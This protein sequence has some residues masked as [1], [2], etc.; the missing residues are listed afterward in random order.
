MGTYVPEKLKSMTF[1]L[2]TVQASNVGDSHSVIALQLA[3]GIAPINCFLVGY[4]GYAGQ[5]VGTKEQELF[6]E[7]DALFED[8]ENNGLKLKSLT[9]TKYKNLVQG[10]IYSEL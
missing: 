4:D 2:Q 3:M 1:E 6:S 8:F 10:S 9:C 7:N 5:I